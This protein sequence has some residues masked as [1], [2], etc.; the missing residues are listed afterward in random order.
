M[1]HLGIRPES[2]I[3]KSAK[4][5]YKYT[6]RVAGKN[7][8]YYECWIDYNENQIKKVFKDDEPPNKP[9]IRAVDK[10]VRSWKE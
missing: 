5:V 8:R 7:V 3:P 1:R 4:R 6:K 2:D 9:K 10:I